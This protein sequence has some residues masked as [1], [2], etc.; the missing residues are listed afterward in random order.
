[1]AICVVRREFWGVREVGKE[2]GRE[3]VVMAV[4][5]VR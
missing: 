2:V 3:G 1:M 4:V 5:V